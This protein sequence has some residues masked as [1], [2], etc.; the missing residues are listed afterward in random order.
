MRTRLHL[1]LIPSPPGPLVADD[2][3]GD[4]DSVLH[5]LACAKGLITEAREEARHVPANTHDLDL[6]I[7]GAD[8]L[9]DQAIT[10]VHQNRRA[11]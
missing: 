10:W 9:V 4:L 7:Q 2:M 1:R 11:S 5:D 3:D 6:L 8:A